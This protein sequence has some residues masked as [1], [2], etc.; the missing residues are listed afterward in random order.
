MLARHRRST[1]MPCASVAAGWCG[2]RGY[3]GVSSDL[4][5]CVRVL[6]STVFIHHFRS[7]SSSLLRCFCFASFLFLLLLPL[8]L[9]ILFTHYYF[10]F[11]FI[12]FYTVL[13]CRWLSGSLV[14]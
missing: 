4:P 14:L 2:R 8:A 5:V 7:S 12:S 9:F 3:P 11:S 6:V 13:V 10:H 1:V